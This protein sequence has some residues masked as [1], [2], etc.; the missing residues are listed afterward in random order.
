M[1]TYILDT[2]DVDKEQFEALQSLPDRIKC[3]KGMFQK[4]FDICMEEMP[5]EGK[6]KAEEFYKETG[7][8]A[9]EAFN[10]PIGFDAWDLPVGAKLERIE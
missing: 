4:D 7:K 5:E 10:K 8:Y 6:Q 1:S 3:K 2:A 9:D